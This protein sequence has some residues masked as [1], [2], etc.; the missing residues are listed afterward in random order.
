MK[1]S[2]VRSSKKDFT[3]IYLLA[4]QDFDDLPDFRPQESDTFPLFM[5][6]MAELPAVGMSS[7]PDI[8]VPPIYNGG[9]V[10]QMMV[11]TSPAV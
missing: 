3:Y 7:S 8:I 5:P 11:D 2:V 4:G 9:G 10:E 6:S 1:C